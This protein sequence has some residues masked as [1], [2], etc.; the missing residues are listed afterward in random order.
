MHDDFLAPI[1]N[2]PLACFVIDTCYG[3][4]AC[5]CQAFLLLQKEIS[6]DLTQYF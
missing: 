1:I 5:D 2:G 4:R 6:G 3:F